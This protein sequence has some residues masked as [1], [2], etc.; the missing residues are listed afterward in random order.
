M[1]KNR[2]PFY[3]AWIIMSSFILFSG[4]AG[5]RPNRPNCH[6]KKALKLAESIEDFNKNI[7]SCT[8]IGWI[9]V[10]R[11]GRIDKFRAAWAV[12]NHDKIRL[13]LMNSGFPV[14]TII[15]D[16]RKVIFLS[17]THKHSLYKINSPNPSL[18]DILSIPVKVRDIISLL[19]GQIPI[20]TFDYA[21]LLKTVNPGKKTLIL[22]KKWRTGAQQVIFDPDNIIRAYELFGSEDHLMYSVSFSEFNTCGVFQIPF[23]IIIRDSLDRSLSL[24]IT[25]Y[26]VNSP[27]KDSAFS[28]T[29]SG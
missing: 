13:T 4:C 14:E 15:A 5:L 2:I 26:R 8:G 23:K 21:C 17:H 20:K 24:E 16:G 19:S 11:K 7:N 1:N 9:R 12:L 28:L 18:A 6:D 27:V 25:G 22:H 29:E 3:F 10:S